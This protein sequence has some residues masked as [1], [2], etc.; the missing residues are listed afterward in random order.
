MEKNYRNGNIKIV[1]G[2]LTL[3]ISFIALLAISGISIT[4]TMVGV[5]I[6]SQS[7]LSIILGLIDFEKAKNARNQES[8]GKKNVTADKIRK[9]F[10]ADLMSF[11]VDEIRFIT[12]EGKHQCSTLA[13]ITIIDAISAKEGII[14]ITPNDTRWIVSGYDLKK[15]E[16]YS[17]D[18][19]GVIRPNIPGE[20]Q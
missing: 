18:N 15:T 13:K 2:T 6:V 17:V 9:A 16:S 5:F 20:K 10:G 1:I 8:L 7:S 19:K 4:A 12:D 14:T 3:A 11:V